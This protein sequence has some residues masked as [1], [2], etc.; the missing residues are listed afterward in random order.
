MN[1]S[2]DFLRLL[3]RRPIVCAEGY[4]FELERRGYIQAGPFV[5][6]TVLDHPEAVTQLHRE[7]LRAGSDIMVA[8][9]YYAHREKLR[10]IE[11]EDVLEMLNRRALQI[12]RNV[13]SE[14]DAFVAGNICNTNIY[15]PDDKKTL[16]EVRGM[17]QEQLAW[18]VDEG[19]DLVVGET[20]SFLG[21]ALIALEQIRET[22][23]PAVITLAVH[24][25]IELRDGVSL[26]EAC[27]TLEDNGAAVVGL[28]C[29]RGPDTMLPL[30]APIVEAVTIP[31]AAL[32]VPYRTTREQPT[33]QSLR[34]SGYAGCSE[35]PFPTALDPFTCT[36]DET[37]RFARKAV[38]LGCRY[39]GL[40][41][42]AGPHHIRAMA[43]ELGLH[44]P[45]SKYS[46]DM[47]KHF[48]FGDAAAV[49]DVNRGWHE[50]L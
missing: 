46:P 39:I 30:L 19:A 32:P 2:E 23:L 48:A 35:R 31:V 38:D 36:R 1:R 8:L 40:C 43:E 37:A 42:G 20:F 44:P 16:Q 21:E 14:G 18:C 26:V 9:T 13:A 47:T 27:K 25:Q 5:P 12:A 24:R 10:V 7:F 15:A 4:I 50:H 17:F 22:G 28:N 49:K 33:F 6:D 3:Q 29:M 11:R 41:C 34:D 45:A